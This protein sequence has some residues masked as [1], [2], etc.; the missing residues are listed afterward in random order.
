MSSD[1]MKD[2]FL[3]ELSEPRPNPGG[4]SASAHGALLALCIAEKVARLELA[5]HA[6]GK[7][8]RP[9][10]S[11][12]AVADLKARLLSLRE[13]DTQAYLKLAAD[14]ASD[15]KDSE[16]AEALVQA[17]NCPLMIVRV[18]V[19]VLACVAEVGDYCRKH[20]ISDLQ[21]ALEFSF[22]A[23][24]GA[25]HIA[26]ANAK[27]TPDS[28]PRKKR[29]GLLPPIEKDAERA[30]RYASELLKSRTTGK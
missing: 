24:R 3:E 17:I 19:R 5:R 21:V 16:F 25:F 29:L 13:E 27:L 26:R 6:E 2:S 8:T 11:L 22:A 7:G 18:S 15:V 10:R 23:I 28:A 1:L 12:A 4:G 14:R 20:L 30:Y 9:E